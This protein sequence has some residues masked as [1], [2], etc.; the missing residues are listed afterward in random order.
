M[1]LKNQLK[2]VFQLA[3]AQR[4]SRYEIKI[5]KLNTEVQQASSGKLF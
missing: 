4:D 2:L 1:D 3:D 5:E